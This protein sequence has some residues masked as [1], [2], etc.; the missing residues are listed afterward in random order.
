MLAGVA[1]IGPSCRRIYVE[2]A[3]PF[4]EQL[5]NRGSGPRAAPL[6]DL[7]QQSGADAFRHLASLRSRWHELGEVQPPLRDRVDAG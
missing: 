6:V 7:T 3:E 4:V 1:L 5:A 2:H